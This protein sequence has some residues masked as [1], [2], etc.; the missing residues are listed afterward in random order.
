M[1]PSS[2]YPTSIGCSSIFRQAL[3]GALKEDV[4]KRLRDRLS[5]E[6]IS[7]V[8]AVEK[9]HKVISNETLTIL[10]QQK[11]IDEQYLIQF[12]RIRHKKRG[13]PQKRGPVPQRVG[14]EER[15]AI[16]DINTQL[17]H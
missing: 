13:E 12:L 3:R 10:L 14:I 11:D 5:P 1:N 15:P 7:G 6:Q 16:V 2:I 17:G 8:L 4:L 9:D